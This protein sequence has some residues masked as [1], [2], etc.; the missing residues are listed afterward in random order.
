MIRF[1]GR[2]PRPMDVNHE[3][4]AAYEKPVLSLSQYSIRSYWL[5]YSYL[6]IPRDIQD[7]V[8]K[9]MG[10]VKVSLKLI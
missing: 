10:N 5:F 6:I 4:F 1:S 3:R 2:S 7:P 8:S 9:F